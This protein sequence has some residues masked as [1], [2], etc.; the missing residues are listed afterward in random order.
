MDIEWHWCILC[1]F[2]DLAAFIDGPW[3][4]WNLRATL[5]RFWWLRIRTES[6]WFMSIFRI[7]NHQSPKESMCSVFIT[8]GPCSLMSGFPM[9]SLFGSY[10][11]I[12][13]CTAGVFVG[14]CSHTK[15]LAKFQAAFVLSWEGRKDSYL[16][17]V[18]EAASSKWCFVT[19][20]W[21]RIKNLALETCDRN[22]GMVFWL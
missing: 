19:S 22:A 18:W 3:R 21:F 11:Q 20:L 12:A 5:P 15:S 9:I 16:R 4:S 7:I 13:G 6:S 17:P 2:V 10:S 8:G 1:M 14:R